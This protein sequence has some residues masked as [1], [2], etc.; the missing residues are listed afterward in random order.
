MND[1]ST[2][3]WKVLIAVGIAM[4][5][6]AWFALAFHLGF[7]GRGHEMSWGERISPSESYVF[8]SNETLT[9]DDLEYIAGLRNLSSLTLYECNV[10][11]CNLP[12]IE[13]KSKNLWSV[14]LSGT[15]GLWDLSFLSKLPA[16]TL[17]L[18]DCPGIDDISMLNWDV[19]TTLKIDGTDV[20]SLAPLEGS[21]VSD[22]SFARTKVSD[23]SPLEHLEG[24]LWQVDGSYSEVSSL[25]SLAGANDLW[26][27]V[28]DG[29]PIEEI[30]TPF[31][32][33]RL[34]EVSLAHT[35]VSDLTG[36]SGCKSILTLD[37]T[38]DENVD[39][40][41]W[42]DPGCYETLEG[43]CLGGTSCD[44]YD[45]RWVSSCRNL[46]KLTLDGIRLKDLSICE[47]LS[48][49]ETISAINCGLTDVSSL[50]HCPK[51]ATVMLGY[52]RLE[53][54]EGIP[55]PA[56]EY[57]EMILDLSHNQLASVRDLPSGKYECIMLQGNGDEVART[58]P[59]GV[60]SY[61]VTI[62]WCSGLEDTRLRDREQFSYIYLLG[63][64]EDRKNEMD[65]AFSS[66]R[67]KHVDE[68]GFLE[69]LESDS[70]IYDPDGVLV[71]YVRIARELNEG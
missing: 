36:L 65:Y 27:I 67:V 1:Q 28:F 11:E 13:F 45:I 14:D 16:E 24:P 15:K 46:T 6:V 9:Q 32:T 10:A 61:A 19:L 39:D 55:T 42:I 8:V 31:A 47:R 60:E 20:T 53:S 12:K 17:R 59:S 7:L 29:C 2:V 57:R 50:A 25:D 21:K 38:G 52:N 49:L 30:S 66:W 18:I 44:V 51:L 33:D 63:C 62:D 69:V 48:D 43:L 5:T 22:I 23:L 71:N 68:E 40:L 34:Y 54:V 58:I 56:H 35:P 26:G 3:K 41:S 70:F 37:L 64:P 4:A